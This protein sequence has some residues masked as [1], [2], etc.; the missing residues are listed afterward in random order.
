MK[1]A[2]LLF[3]LVAWPARADF[4]T[5]LA[6]HLNTSWGENWLGAFELQDRFSENSYGQDRLLVRPSVGYQIGKRHSLWLGYAWTPT[7]YPTF[8]DEHRFWQQALAE[9]AWGAWTLTFR[10]RMENRFIAGS[11]AILW[12]WRELARL[13]YAFNDTWGLVLWDEAFFSLNGNAVV[14]RGFDQNRFFFGPEFTLREGLRLQSGYLNVLV[15]HGGGVIA[16]HVLAVSL[17][18]QLNSAE[19]VPSP[20]DA[21]KPPG[22]G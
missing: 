18:W 13:T 17:Y 19:P 3:V 7:F 20:A 4:E 1:R 2:A 10:F 8:R 15:S 16:N 14:S 21:D 6:G 5:W 11:G 9:Y 22:R 12:R